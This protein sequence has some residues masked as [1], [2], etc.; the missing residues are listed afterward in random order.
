MRLPKEAGQVV[1]H[2]NVRRLWNRRGLRS[3][4]TFYHLLER[5][6]SPLEMVSAMRVASGNDG[7]FGLLV[8]N[9]PTQQPIVLGSDLLVKA[10]DGVA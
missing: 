4:S 8:G 5:G 6:K 2:T 7:F 9:E 10:V 1:G 3:A